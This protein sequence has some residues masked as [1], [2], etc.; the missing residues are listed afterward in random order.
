METMT[1]PCRRCLL[2]LVVLLGAGA[3]KG[4]RKQ[5]PAVDA[6]SLADMDVG[7]PEAGADQAPLDGT[8]DPVDSVAPTGVTV[9]PPSSDFGTVIQGASST[10]PTLLTVTNTGLAIA[11]N[12][13]VI[14]PFAMVSN[15]CAILAAGKDC[16]IGLTFNPVV[17]G[18]AS[19]VLTVAAGVT[20]NLTGTGVA[21][22]SLAFT[23]PTRSVGT[24]IGWASAVISFDLVNSGGADS[25]ALTVTPGGDVGQF[26]IDNQCLAPLS[27]LSSCQIN[28]VFKPTVFS[29]Q[30]TLTLTVTDANSPTTPILATV[31]GVAGDRGAITSSGS[32]D[33]GTVAVGATSPAHQFT[34]TNPAAV[35][36]GILTI[37]VTDTQFVVT[38]D[39]CSTLPLA[40]GKSCTL[41]I[42]FKPSIPGTWGATL[43]I[44]A[45]G[46]A[47]STLPIKGMSVANPG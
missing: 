25:G 22:A 24:P 33:F 3:C 27:A 20:A 32:G 18:P 28:V 12:P 42:V 38:S 45:P 43:S 34:L 46:W 35:D 1:T 9:S 36:S 37:T 31:Y 40:A 10:T 19:G 44:S 17:L 7:A 11:L 30:S 8:P 16:T 2:G 26:T 41:S 23:K 14:G 4:P 15:T 13:T 47:I 21:P 5:T 39:G 29:Q 6:A